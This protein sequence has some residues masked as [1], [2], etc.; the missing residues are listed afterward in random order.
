MMDSA[1][2]KS[3]ETPNKK[4]ELNNK[5]IRKEAVHY[6]QLTMIMITMHSNVT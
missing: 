4:A 5:I 3:Q 2:F 1:C 6:E